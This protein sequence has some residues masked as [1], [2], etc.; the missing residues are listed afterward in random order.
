MMGALELGEGGSGCQNLS[1]ER[2]GR[3]LSDG[4]TDGAEEPTAPKPPQGEVSHTSDTHKNIPSSSFYSY[5]QI[6]RI[7][8]SQGFNLYQE[9]KG[10]FIDSIFQSF[11]TSQ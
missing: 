2:K 10:I 3:E 5:L 4:E 8:K 11:K 1:R 9:L 6:A 7:P